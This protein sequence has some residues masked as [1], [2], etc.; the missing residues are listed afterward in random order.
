MSH[1]IYKLIYYCFTIELVFS[2]FPVTHMHMNLFALI[3]TIA[4]NDNM[5]VKYIGTALYCAKSILAYVII[6]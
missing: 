2:V 1:C 6:M 5:N 4:E 3:Q